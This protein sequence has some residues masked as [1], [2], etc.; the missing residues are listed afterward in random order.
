MRG[1]IDL[2]EWG[3]NP[4]EINFKTSLDKSSPQVLTVADINY[5]QIPQITAYKRF[6]TSIS[7]DETDDQRIKVG[8]DTSAKIDNVFLKELQKGNHV[9]LYSY[10]DDL[11]R[12]VFCI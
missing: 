4:S 12:K 10:H 7:L 2:K 11:K 1:Y 8:R 9:T 6:T 5:F 3:N